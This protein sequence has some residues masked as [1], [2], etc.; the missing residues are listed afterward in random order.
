MPKR[1]Y[2]IQL[3]DSERD[4]LRKMVKTGTSPARSI[5]RANIILLSETSAQRKPLTVS[6]V[7]KS[8]QTTPTTVQTVRTAYAE[9]GLEAVL[10]RKKR[11]D[12]PVVPKVDGSLEAHIIALCCSTAPEG[13]ARWTLRLLADKCV[14]LGYINAISHTTISRT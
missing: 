5:L 14:E 8:L 12:P 7:A 3:T 9:Q 1:K 6:A 2:E 10:S 4:K 13:Y 11:Q